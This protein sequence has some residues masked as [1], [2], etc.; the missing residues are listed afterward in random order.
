MEKLDRLELIQKYFREEL[1]PE[2]LEAFQQLE[3]DPDFREELAEYEFFHDLLE[4]GSLMEEEETLIN[5]AAPEPALNEPRFRAADLGSSSKPHNMPGDNGKNASKPNASHQQS[6]LQLRRSKG[7]RYAIAAT[8]LLVLVFGLTLFLNNQPR[9]QEK[10]TGTPPL[11]THAPLIASISYKE[12]SDNTVRDLQIPDTTFMV[13]IYPPTEGLNFHY[14]FGFP[15]TLHLYGKFNPK[16]LMLIYHESSMEYQL[17]YKTNTY[18]LE[19]SN[20]VSPLT[21]A[22]E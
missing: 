4:A 22:R 5:R 10:I 13:Y 11:T 20:K 14:M 9:R 15:D 7:I 3:H 8:A 12:E 16:D 18:L 2:E 19:R 1:N 17:T 6:P 21:P